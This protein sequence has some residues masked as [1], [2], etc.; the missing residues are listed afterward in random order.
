M[1]KKIFISIL[2]GYLGWCALHPAIFHSVDYV[3][4]IIHEA[5]H[6]VFFLGGEFISV[7]GGSFLQ[8]FFPLVFVGY[9]FLQGDQ[10]GA[11][12]T[13]AWAGESL[14]NVS[15]Y[16]SDGFKMELDLLGGDGVIHDWNYILNVFHSV[17]YAERVGYIVWVVSIVVV[18]A[19]I[20][21]IWV[22]KKEPVNRA[23]SLV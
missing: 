7:L 23:G 8:V 17:Q 12:A 13:L 22:P 15:N 19:A 21:F 20:I 18:A 3:N 14:A 11:V 5:G 4:L 1:V 2:V 16:I 10:I 9:F 6:W